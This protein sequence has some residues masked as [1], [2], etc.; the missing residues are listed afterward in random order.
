[1]EHANNCERFR[2]LRQ[3]LERKLH[4][5]SLLVLFDLNEDE[6]LAFR[7]R[8]TELTS[9]LYRI[10]NCTVQACSIPRFA[11]FPLLHAM[12]DRCRWLSIAA[13]RWHQVALVSSPMAAREFCRAV[14]VP[15]SIRLQGGLTLK[16]LNGSDVDVVGAMFMVSG[17][18]VGQALMQMVPGPTSKNHPSRYGRFGQWCR[19]G[20]RRRLSV[21]VYFDP[22]LAVGE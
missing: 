10:A 7:T 18:H 22:E 14:V 17:D 13:Q 5:G 21:Q 20:R 3:S 9:V 11:F 12:R 16:L 8:G 4:D 1:L 6:F 2:Y 15:H 19:G